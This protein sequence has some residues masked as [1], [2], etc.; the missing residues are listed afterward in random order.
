MKGSKGTISSHKINKAWGCNVQHGVYNAV[1]YKAVVV[2]NT[3][4]HIQ[5]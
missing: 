2:Y 3:I 1:V 5:K 4:L